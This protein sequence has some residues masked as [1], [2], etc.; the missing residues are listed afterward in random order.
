MSNI[1]TEIN[2]IYQEIKGL[3]A[4]LNNAEKSFLDNDKSFY[5]IANNIINRVPT[6][7]SN[8]SD[9][10]MYLIEHRVFTQNATGTSLY[11]DIVPTSAKINTLLGRL[12][13]LFSIEKSIKESGPTFIQHQTQ[14]QHQTMSI[15]LGL[16]EKILNEITNHAEGTPERNFLDKLKTTLPN[17]SDVLSIISSIL[18]IGN[19][20]GVGMETI[21]KLLNL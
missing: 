13:G 2:S 8:I 16:Q 4:S 1:P 14:N 7:C 10:S 20:T 12:N 6:V 18:T 15:V 17:V 11:I 19:E 21:K 9:V 3:L 5:K